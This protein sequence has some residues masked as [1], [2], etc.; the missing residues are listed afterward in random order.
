MDLSFYIIDVLRRF[1]G[2]PLGGKGGR[3]PLN[4]AEITKKLEETFPALE[5]KLLREGQTESRVVRVALKRM[6]ENQFD[7]PE[8]NWFLRCVYNDGETGPLPR[9]GKGRRIIGYW[10]PEPEGFRDEEL[11]FLIDSVMYSGILSNEVAQSLA[12]RLQKLGGK[13]LHRITPYTSGGFGARRSD[14]LSD[15]DLWQNLRVIQ[16]GI[17]KQRQISF[18]LCVYRLKGGRVVLFPESEHTLSPV[19]LV[20]HNGRYYLLGAYD[21]SDNVYFSRVDLMKKVELKGADFPGRD[22]R[23]VPALRSFWRGSYQRKYPIM[24]GREIQRFRL[25][26]DKEHLTQV[27]DTFGE[28]LRLLPNTETAETVDVEVEASEGAMERWILSQGDYLQV[29]NPDKDFLERLRQQIGLL[30]EKYGD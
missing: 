29:V 18:Q 15:T 11:R 20:L 22:R 19:E 26:C 6:A 23:N 27:V 4:K 30:E 14:V 9:P 13:E 17:Q 3:H 24:F 25:R 28:S 2:P 5:G 7:L 8:E 21:K 10:A 12:K 1:A 16:E